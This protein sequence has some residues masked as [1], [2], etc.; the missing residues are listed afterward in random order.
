MQL[1]GAVTSCPTNT[2]CG[3]APCL[4]VLSSEARRG[5]DR[6]YRLEGQSLV[7]SGPRSTRHTAYCAE[8]LTIAVSP[9]KST[10]PEAW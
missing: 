5:T 9:A 10:R 2:W 8:I 1:I 6:R 4:L 7:T 3:G